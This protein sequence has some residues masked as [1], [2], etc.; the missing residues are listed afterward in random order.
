VWTMLLS[1][2]VQEQSW[3]GFKSPTPLSRD[4]F[5]TKHI[6]LPIWYVSYVL[7]A[8]SVKRN[9]ANT[10]CILLLHDSYVNKKL[11]ST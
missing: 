6:L 5:H 3:L 1:F 7:H 4:L 11:I 10:N 8:T 9:Y 2:S